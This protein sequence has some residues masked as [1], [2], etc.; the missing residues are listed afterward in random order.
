MPSVIQQLQKRGLCDAPKW[1]GQNVHYETVMG[2]IAYGVS[3]DDS[4]EDLYSFCIPPKDMVFPHL[5]GK[6]YGF[7]DNF[8][9][10]EQFQQ[11]H[12]HDKESRKE[13]DIQ[14]FSIIKFFRLLM[15]NNPN[16][17]DALFTPTRCIR[18]ITRIGQE[19]R[20]KRDLFLHKGC[21][22][23][24]K[25]YAYSQMHKINT[26]NHHGLPE[27]LEW[28]E[29]HKIP[30]DTTF[31]EAKGSTKVAHLSKE[32]QKE[33]IQLYTKMLEAGGR[34]ERTKIHGYDS[35]FAYHVVRLVDE[36]RQILSEHTLVLDPPDRREMLKAVRNGEWTEEQLRDW[37]SDKERLYSELFQNSKLRDG[38]DRAAIKAL[39]LHC[40]EEHYGSLDK[41]V[42]DVADR[43]PLLVRD[44]QEVLRR[45]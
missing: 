42:Q 1:L 27:L 20:D 19:I 5:A 35:K 9:I 32:E 33:Y 45:Y 29:A 44:I 26:K 40:L 3:T 6:I 38:P 11:H 7:D 10:F 18:H 13:Y 21:W 37:F 24:F 28:E 12:I 8:N 31:E 16:M 43:T 15:D 41:M 23:K 2:S 4:D 36:V 14:C 39:L 34:S 17:I 30:R 25:G 22:A